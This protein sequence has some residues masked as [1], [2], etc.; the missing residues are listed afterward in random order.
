MYPEKIAV[1]RATAHRVNPL[2]SKDSNADTLYQLTQM[3]EQ[4]GGVLAELNEQTDEMPTCGWL[5]LSVCSTISAALNYEAQ[6][7]DSAYV[8]KA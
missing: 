4:L 1:D 8:D 2:I 7:V 6:Q 5:C 3:V